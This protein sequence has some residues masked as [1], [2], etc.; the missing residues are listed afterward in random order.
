[1]DNGVTMSKRLG[2]AKVITADG[3][4]QEY[5]EV[6]ILD[7][8]WIRVESGWGSPGSSQYEYLSPTEARHIYEV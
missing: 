5:P 7:S 8:G 2:E 3:E 4:E 1:M 6:F